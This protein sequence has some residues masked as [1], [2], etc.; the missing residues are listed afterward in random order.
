MHPRPTCRAGPRELLPPYC[1]PPP[2]RSR[3]LRAPATLLFAEI[4]TGREELDHLL[5]MVEVTGTGHVRCTAEEKSNM[6]QSHS[7]DV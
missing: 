5:V 3:Q 1:A 2:L 6:E 7:K 4:I